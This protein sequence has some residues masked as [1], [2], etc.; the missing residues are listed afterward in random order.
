M[1]RARIVAVLRSEVHRD[2]VFPERRDP[3]SREAASR[4]KKLEKVIGIPS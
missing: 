4:Q 1:R 2:A 3:P